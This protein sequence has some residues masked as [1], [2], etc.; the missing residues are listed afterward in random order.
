MRSS[1]STRQSEYPSDV[2]NAADDR[3]LCALAREGSASS[4][5]VLVRK[6]ARLV[7]SCARP[8][9]LV[10]A[11]GEDLIQEGMIGLIKAVREFDPDKADSFSAFALRC[12]KNS[13]VSAVRSVNRQKHSP[14]NNYVSIGQPLFDDNA[15]LNLFLSATAYDPEALMMDKEA[16]TELRSVLSGLLSAFEANV[17]ALYLS[18]LRYEEM[19][20]TLKKPQK[21]IDNAVQRIRRKLAHH[22]HSTATTGDNTCAHNKLPE[23]TGRD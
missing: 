3:R 18:G 21:S 9:F 4:E 17:L 8:Y 11:D 13:I 20:E 19:A 22:L 16:V 23:K 2:Q 6:Y 5:D 14:L 7:R 12:I 15:E 1:Y 10:G